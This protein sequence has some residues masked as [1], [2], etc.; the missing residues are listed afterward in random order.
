MLK[1]A[2]LTF[3]IRT[4]GKMEKHFLSW[5][6]K[7]DEKCEGRRRRRGILNSVSQPQAIN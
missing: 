5:L 4:E 2:V 7:R 1:V 3:E 6:S